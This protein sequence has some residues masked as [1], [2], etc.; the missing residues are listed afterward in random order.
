MII[1]S[2]VERFAS[3]RNRISS[4]DPGEL[5]EATASASW[6]RGNYAC[7]AGNVGVKGTTSWNVTVLD[8]RT[9]GSETIEN[10]GQPFIIATWEPRYNDPPRFRYV[11]IAEV[12]DGLSHTL[13]F[14]EC[15]RGGHDPSLHPYRD[16]RGGV[17]H[18]AFCWFTTWLLPNTPDPDGN[19]DS[20]RC[21]VPTR[22]APC[23]SATVA[24]GPSAMAARSAHPGG[25]H[26]CMLDG[27]ARFVGDEIEWSTWQALGTAAGGETTGEF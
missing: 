20:Y 11:R 3:S 17:Y 25:V 6:W 7:N 12:T 27:S 22:N 15:F 5:F 8:S 26:V 23:V 18:A 14:A 2:V 16:I 13:A 9:L 21:C 1:E 4:S 19:P 24:G 10:G